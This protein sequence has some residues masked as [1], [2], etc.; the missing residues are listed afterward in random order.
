MLLKCC[1]ER[2]LPGAD[3]LEREIEMGR[4]L[5]ELSMG[6]GQFGVLYPFGSYYALRSW[7]DVDVT[8][9]LHCIGVEHDPVSHAG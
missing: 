1:D 3:V 7:I 8:S 6:C 4:G 5:F 2:L 9:T